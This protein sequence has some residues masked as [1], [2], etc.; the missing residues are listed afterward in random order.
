MTN[1]QI[2]REMRED[3]K[4]VLQSRDYTGILY[5]T[6][7]DYMDAQ[8]N[9]L[10]EF[11]LTKKIEGCRTTTIKDYHDKIMKL[12]EWSSKDLTELTTK[13]IRMFLANYQ[14]THSVHDSTM[15][16]IR[17]VLSTFFGFLENEEYVLRNPVKGV[18]K[19]R[20]DE[21]IRLPFT[22][23]EIEIIRSAVRNLRDLA[24]IDL[25]MSSGMRIGELTE[26][27]IKDIN[28][29][30]REMIVYG[31]GGKER[32]CYFNARTK[33][34]ILDYLNTRVDKSP[35][36]F[37]QLKYPYDRLQRGGIR[38]MLKDIEDRTGIDNIHPHRFR[39]T[40]ATNLL[41]KGMSLEQVQIILGHKRIETTLVYEKV[42]QN[43]TKMNHQKY[44]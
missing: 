35:A 11:L 8:L 16:Q 9:L 31:K 6:R 38:H 10:K 40:L 36:L 26:L 14:M 13:D 32:I 19:I 29:Q 24:I 15:D 22:D 33:I 1:D 44:T 5:Y 43:L 21:K 27:N 28:F 41:N 2:T 17:L 7:K 39:R 34:E 23:E 3:Q 30:D 25:F 37:V 42:N 18:R 4:A 20:V 12:I